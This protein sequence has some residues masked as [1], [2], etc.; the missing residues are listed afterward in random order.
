V[1]GQ[2]LN[3]DEAHLLVR[4]DLHWDYDRHHLIPNEMTPQIEDNLQRQFAHGQRILE[5]LRE[6]Q[7][8]YPVTLHSMGQRAADSYFAYKRIEA[9]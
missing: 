8:P 3:W 9:S 1:H 2:T 5:F 6:C 4:N 7:L